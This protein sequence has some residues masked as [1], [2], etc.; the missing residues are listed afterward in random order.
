MKKIYLF[1]LFAA[2]FLNCANAQKSLESFTPAT[3]EEMVRNLRNDFRDAY[4]EP[5]ANDFEAPS[6]DSRRARSNQDYGFS[7]QGCAWIA[8]AYQHT[9][10]GIPYGSVYYEYELVGCAS[11]GSYP[12]P[13]PT[14]YTPHA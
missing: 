6:T 8:H 3:W 7:Y 13:P 4:V 2:V 11:G 1:I 14:I 5:A 10:L 12:D 9:F